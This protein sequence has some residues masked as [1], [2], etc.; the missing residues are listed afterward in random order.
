MKLIFEQAK[1]EVLRLFWRNFPE[2][3]LSQ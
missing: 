2:S 1:R 3:T